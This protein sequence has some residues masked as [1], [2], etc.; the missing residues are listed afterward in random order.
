MV[1]DATS[2]IF[3]GR[4]F[5]KAYVHFNVYANST[6]YILESSPFY[7]EKISKA[8]G[9]VQFPSYEVEGDEATIIRNLVE[10]RTAVQIYLSLA[11]NMASE[12]GSRLA[13]MDG[14]QKACKERAVEYE[15]IYQNLRKS[16]IT[17]E[18]VVTA[19]GVKTIEADKKRAAA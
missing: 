19:A 14:A 11:E 3:E 13:S 2:H 16:K 12:N 18:L 17:N 7:S 5:D 8:I 9:E 6:K 15:K 1:M 10:Y 4:E